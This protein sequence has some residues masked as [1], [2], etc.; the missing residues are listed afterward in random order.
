M[1]TSYTR[2]SDSCTVTLSF[3]F[4]NLNFYVSFQ[5]TNINDSHTPL[6]RVKQAK[7]DF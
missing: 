2:S 1:P 3:V 5:M 4:L 7:A 6:V